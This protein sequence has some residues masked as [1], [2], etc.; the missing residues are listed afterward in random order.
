MN[1]HRS[2]KAIGYMPVLMGQI[3]GFL[4]RYRNPKVQQAIAGM[5]RQKQAL[6]AA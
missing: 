3:E 1:R 2:V 6:V 5:H 4:G